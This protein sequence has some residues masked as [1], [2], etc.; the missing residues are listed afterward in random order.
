ML[1]R[2]PVERLD[3]I[4]FYGIG[5][6]FARNGFDPLPFREPLAAQRFVKRGPADVELFRERAIRQIGAVPE[7]SESE[8]ER[9][10]GVI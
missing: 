5:T 10:R 4:Y 9:L 1:L 3:L 2:K 6:T 7:F 8:R